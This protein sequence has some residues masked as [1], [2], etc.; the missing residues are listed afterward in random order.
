MLQAVDYDLFL[1]AN[2]TYLLFQYKD[3]EPIKEEL[4]KNFF[5]VCDWVLDHKL[6]I[7]FGEDK[8]KSILFS[9]K[10]RKRKIGNLDEQFADAKI[11]Q[12]SKVTYL[13][14]EFDESLLGEAM[15]LKYIKINSRL[16]F[17]YS[18]NR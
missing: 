18:K 11:K 3:P 15:P 9:T 6:R 13:G 8:T 5:N 16:K 10:N 7:H 17:L 12:Y 1:Y 4:I 2:D 14:C